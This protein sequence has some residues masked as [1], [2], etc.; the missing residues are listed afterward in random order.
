MKTATAFRWIDAQADRF[1]EFLAKIC[2]FETP[3]TEKAE[4]DAMADCIAD[5][6]KGLGL[7]VRRTPFETC[8]D[9]LTIDLNEGAEKDSVFL[10][11]MDTV[12]EKGRFGFPAVR[13]EGD[14]MIGPG[15]IDCK[16]GIA[17]ALL[18]LSALRESGYQK[19]AR[20]ILT[21]DEEVSNVLGGE[22]EQVFFCESVQGFRY[23]L[24]CEVA[25]EREVVV[26]RKGIMRYKIEVQGKGG[27]AGIH[28][29]ECKN[30]VLES[31]KKIVELESH[32]AP[33]KCTYS[34]NVI[35]AG[36]VSN[37]IPDRCSFTNCTVSS[38]L[39]MG[40]ANRSLSSGGGLVTV[41]PSFLR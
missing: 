24:N 7:S 40:Q 31:A 27:H 29:F 35:Q 17:V 18:A 32:S 19:H 10:A 36:S 13:T 26:A 5:F 37:V 22:R 23:A 9:F 11:H 34:C 38:G 16:G 2:S 12:H 28:Y 6:A 41:V 33:D 4:L 8:G 1:V 30:A 15:T 25:E 3:A 21:S 14:R 20:L 39:P